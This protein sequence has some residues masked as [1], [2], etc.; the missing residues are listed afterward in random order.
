MHDGIL[1]D[2]GAVA[3]DCGINVMGDMNGPALSNRE[4]V[5]DAHEMAIAAKH[6]AACDDGAGA[7]FDLAEH[8]AA[9]AKKLRRRSEPRLDA[10]E[11]EK[12]REG[13]GKQFGCH[14]RNIPVLRRMPNLFVTERAGT[15]NA[16]FLERGAI[17]SKM[18]LRPGFNPL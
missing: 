12:E 2:G 11:R 14:V 9:P 10:I 1:A 16:L 3:D 8:A 6:R 13:L 7:N 17:V 5:S 18:S 15:L 4:A